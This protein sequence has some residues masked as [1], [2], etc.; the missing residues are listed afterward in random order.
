[1][2]TI[3]IEKASPM[4]GTEVLGVDASVHASA[5]TVE[6]LGRALAEH[7]VLI[8]RDQHLTAEQHIAFSSLFGS[9]ETHVISGALLEGHPEIY[10][11]SN[12]VEDG[13][14]QGRA[15]AGTYWHSD[16]SYTATPRNTSFHTGPPPLRDPGLRRCT[17]SHAS[18]TR[19]EATSDEGIDPFGAKSWFR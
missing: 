1:M 16:L 11:I 15:Y 8:F 4:V 18:H 19:K 17:A 6:Q 13:K 3:A 10:V 9:L 7:G 2:T 12:V 5:E 14:R